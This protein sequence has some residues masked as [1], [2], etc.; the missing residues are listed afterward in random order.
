MPQHLQILCFIVV[1]LLT[2]TIYGQ[3]YTYKNYTTS[4]GLPSNT[5]Y[6]MA[7][8]NNGYLWVSTGSGASRF[9]GTNFE[10]VDKKDGLI[11][12][13]FG[14]KVD[15]LNRVW[16]DTFT[17]YFVYY[18]DGKIHKTDTIPYL[19]NR[20][21]IL[22]N[23]LKSDSTY[24][25]VLQKE[26][27][28]AQLDIHT[29]ELIGLHTIDD[30][31]H[32][33]R[34]FMT[35]TDQYPTTFDAQICYPEN[36]KA[37]YIEVQ[38]VIF[39]SKAPNIWLND[40]DSTGI[41]Y[42]I[43][44]DSCITPIKK[45][46]ADKYINSVY[47]DKVG[48][49]WFGSQNEGIFFLSYHQMQSFTEKQG[50]ASNAVYSLE[51]DR[52]NKIWVGT[53]NGYVNIIDPDNFNIET[54]KLTDY[55]TKAIDIETQGEQFVWVQMDKSDLFVFDQNKDTRTQYFQRAFNKDLFVDKAS[56]LWFGGTYCLD[57]ALLDTSD[58]SLSFFYGDSI[59]NCVFKKKTFVSFIE[60]GTAWVGSNEGLYKLVFGGKDTLKYFYGDQY[61][62]LNVGIRDIEQV[63]NQLWIGTVS[64]GLVVLD[65]EAN[66]AHSI[67][68]ETH[69][70][71]NN[72]CRELFYDK[73]RKNIWVAHNNGVTKISELETIDKLQFRNYNF[74]DGLIG[75]E[76][77]DVLV[78]HNGVTW[79]A[80]KKGLTCFN[81]S[82]FPERASPPQINIKK[83]S[84][85]DRDT[86]VQSEYIF[87]YQDNDL[88]ILFEGIYF[89][90]SITYKYK[91]EGRDEAWV[92]SKENAVRYS[93]LPPG[94]YVFKV[95]AM[96]NDG[97]ESDGAATIKFKIR[98]P[99]WTTWW[100]ILICLASILG[101]IALLYK[102]R[103]DQLRKENAL[104]ELSLRGLGNQMNAHF[105]FNALNAI[106]NYLLDSETESA[107]RYLTKLSRLIR[108][109][110]YHSNQKK[111]TI[112]DEIQILEN[113]LALETLRVKDSFSYQI[114][115]DEKID[116]NRMQIP[117]M[118]LQP[119]IENSIRWGLKDLDKKG[120]INIHFKMKNE[121]DLL[122]CTIIDNGIG[123]K[124]AQEIKSKY[125][126]DHKSMG[127]EI[128]A[129]RIQLLRDLKKKNYQIEIIDL[130]DDQQGALGTKV[131]LL[132]P[133]EY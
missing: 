100:F 70:L 85:W 126:E 59:I 43:F 22:S 112:R 38:S 2:T 130:Y 14:L 24:L 71:G 96:N 47:E 4:D 1:S 29:F 93:K 31:Y 115:L 118:L 64:N 8:D 74:D 99:F 79:V 114:H 77:T 55:S 94:D 89:H 56:N 107:Y 5:I 12:N 40:K 73:E 106:Q 122:Q 57:K 92:F 44:E 17:P 103:T 33:A 95:L 102:Y 18:F 129:N 51:E 26:G 25:W 66:L 54:I 60:K 109:T 75:N 3:Q 10:K 128:N 46:M 19:N 28:I 41:F 49:L 117:P 37:L 78:D 62:S 84:I 13:I 111:I 11:E 15:A 104:T 121:N 127:T 125:F 35:D 50:M 87:N 105:L 34:T 58:M 108:Q 7:Q 21:E 123:R 97:V 101:A 110:L 30:G 91:L 42:S 98:S 20:H 83:I 53:D 90:G 124:K 69:P 61:P 48:N 52:D 120:E 27:N 119:Y 72:A 133:I 113:Y 32:N 86:I 23:V 88:R 67:S 6:K 45:Y 81:E 39:P 63:A 36:K 116:E 16:F 82:D 80:T 9:N 132:L 131:E 65:D 76:A 68:T